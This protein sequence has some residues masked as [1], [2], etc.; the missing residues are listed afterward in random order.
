VADAVTGPWSFGTPHTQEV[1]NSPTRLVVR[2]SNPMGTRASR[3]MRLRVSL[4]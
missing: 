4:P 2:D 1:E 3:Y